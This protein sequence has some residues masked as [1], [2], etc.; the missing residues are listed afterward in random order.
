MSEIEVTVLPANGLIS[1]KALAK[2][3]GTT[4]VTLIE[5]LRKNQIPFV[6]LSTRHEH[7]MIRLED[8]KAVKSEVDSSD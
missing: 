7:W 4:D 8:L 3:L 6:K 1:L 5:G 2:Y